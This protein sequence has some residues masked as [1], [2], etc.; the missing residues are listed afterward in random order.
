MGL[1]EKGAPHTGTRGATHW[2][3]WTSAGWLARAGVVARPL[4]STTVPRSVGAVAACTCSLWRV[5]DLPFLY[6]SGSISDPG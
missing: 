6:P 3:C 5:L 2:P 4:P 1:L